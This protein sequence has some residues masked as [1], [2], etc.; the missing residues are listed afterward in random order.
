LNSAPVI[1]VDGRV[2]GDGELGEVSKQLQS[3]YRA[4]I[5]ASANH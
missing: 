1:E 5:E 2:I 3:F 4:M